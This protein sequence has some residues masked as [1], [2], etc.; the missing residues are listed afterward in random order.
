MS[1]TRVWVVEGRKNKV[2]G[3]IT[4]T[5]IIRSLLGTYPLHLVGSY[6]R[7]R[8]DDLLWRRCGMFV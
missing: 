5:S 1:V 4:L 6:T 3:L 2:V 7:L 8:S